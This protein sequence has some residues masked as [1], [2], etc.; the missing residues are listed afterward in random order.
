MHER[1]SFL[2]VN[3]Q[4]MVLFIYF[5]MDRIFTERVFAVSSGHF[6]I[7]VAHDPTLTVEDSLEI[8]IWFPRASVK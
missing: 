1:L 2:P 8:C 6:E 5:V 3:K 4:T 7:T